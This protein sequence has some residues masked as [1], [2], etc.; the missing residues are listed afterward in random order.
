M[1]KTLWPVLMALVLTACGTTSGTK[2]T[3]EDR[4]GAKADAAMASSDTKGSASGSGVETSPLGSGNVAGSSMDGG[5]KYSGDPRKDPASP[6]STRSIFFDFDQYVVKDEYRP[7]LEAHAGYLLSKRDARVI[8]QG[9][10]DDRGSREY[11]LALG[12][13][14]AEAVRKALSVLGVGE[15]QMEAVSFGEEK[16]RMEGET[17]EAYAANRRTDIVYSDE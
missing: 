2:A 11:N 3:V 7:V 5:N 9:N 12:Q 15:A 4:T 14:R 13:K 8:L 10:A 6:L 17:E 16:P 1:K